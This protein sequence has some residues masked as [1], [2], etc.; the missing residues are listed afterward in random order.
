MAWRQDEEQVRVEDGCAWVR[1]SSRKRSACLEQDH[2]VGP[3]MVSSNEP[4][5]RHAEKI[6]CDLGMEKAREVST[7]CVQEGATNPNADDGQKGL[8]QP[9]DATKFRSIA[10][11]INYLAADRPDL[12]FASKCASKYM[13]NPT[14]EGLTVLKRIG[15]TSR[16]T[17]G[18][19]KGLIGAF[20]NLSC[21]ATPTL[22]GRPTK[23]LTSQKAEEH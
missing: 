22:F 8:L 11:R 18:W 17:E 14:C 13:A 15:S 5:Q 3:S 1:H 16:H 20:G 19:F 12:Q 7:P 23:A 6:V 21:K 9:P 10:A 2:S 4:D